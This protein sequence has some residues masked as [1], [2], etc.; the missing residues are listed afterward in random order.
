[1]LR[2]LLIVAAFCSLVESVPAAPQ[3]PN[4]DC[5]TFC[6]RYCELKELAA[7]Y[8]RGN[9]QI[10]CIHGCYW[11]LSERQTQPVRKQTR[12][13]HGAPAQSYR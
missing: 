8:D 2:P 9:C 7:G 6:L 10:G 11:Y 3:T 12:P 5:P 13:T 1:M 4:I